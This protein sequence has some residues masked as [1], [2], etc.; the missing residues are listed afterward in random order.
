M[1]SRLSNNGVLQFALVGLGYWGPNHLRVLQNH[2]SAELR[3]ICDQDA[4]RL[5]HYRQ[6]IANGTMSAD[7]I[8]AV[9][10]DPVTDAVILATPIGTH[11]D[12]AK[13]CL[14]AGKHVLVEKPLAGTLEETEQLIELARANDLA[15]MCGYTFLFSPPV[16]EVR[17]RI[18]SGELGEIYFISSSRVNL[19]L[20]QRDASVIWDLGPH[21]FSI[22]NY[23][24]DQVPE[25]ITA[26]GRDSIVEGTPDVAF[27]TLAYENGLIANVELS[28]LA[29]SKLRRT[30]VVGSEKMIVYDDT[31]P[32]QV[33]IFNQ[34]VTYKD[35]ETFGEFQLSYRSGDIISPHLD[36]YEPVAAQLD[37]FTAAIRRGAAPPGHLELAQDVV[38][39]LEAADRS[40]TEE[41]ANV[42]VAAARGAL[43]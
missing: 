37:A 23:W 3:W 34:G 8:D 38:S 42:P 2:E 9:L 6:G 16:R 7:R 32:E 20:H 11:F 14:E 24:L 39:M 1:R 26:Q 29:P 40:L 22:L 43:A 33:K 13:R 25:A 36:S 18:E 17:S 28:W 21:D 12:L 31:A 41:Q 5:E 30:V 10:A 15:M 4:E 19:G 35:P 27:L